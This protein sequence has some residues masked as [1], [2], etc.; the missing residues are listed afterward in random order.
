MHRLASGEKGG[1]MTEAMEAFFRDLL[2]VPGASVDVLLG[3]SDRPVAAAFGFVDDDAYYLYNS[4]FDPE[5]AAASPGVVLLTMLLERESEAGRPR[6][7]LLKGSESYKR[8]LGG[9]PRPL[10]AVEGVV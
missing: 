5:A 3:A 4:S 10:F 8:R 2:G 6:F 7:D 1:F 9:R